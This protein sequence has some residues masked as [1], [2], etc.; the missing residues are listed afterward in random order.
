VH[1]RTSGVA[2]HYANNDEHALAIVRRIVANLNTVKTPKAPLATPKPPAYDPNEIDGI[3]PQSLAIQYD[4]REV[5]VR[6]VDE[7]VFDEFKRLYGTTIVTGFAHIDGIPVGIIANNGILFSESALKA[8]HFIGLC[9]QRRM[10]LLFLQNI[11]GFMVGRKYEAGGIA[12][13]GA[14]MVTAVACA[15]VPKITVLIGGSFG[16][17]NYGMC[18]RAYSPRFLFS[19]PNSRIS[20]MGG[21]QAASVLATVHRDADKW[22]PEQA[23][24]FKVPIRQKYEDEGSPYFAT[25][26]LWDDG[27][28]VPSDTRRVLALALSA[29]LNAPIAPSDFGVYRM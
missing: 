6:L 3:I 28:I 4:V 1:A 21:E 11:A 27:I 18:G 23:E 7:S 13:D 25:A 14:K 5:I 22:T 15:S 8:A 26:R 2:D 9:C 19:W 10:P 29:S 12:K 17:G 20:V 24:A 16:A